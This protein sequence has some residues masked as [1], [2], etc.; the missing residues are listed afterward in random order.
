VRL[1][2]D[3]TLCRHKGPH[4]FGLGNHLDAA[5]STK[6]TKVF[7]FGHVW[8]VLALVVRVP[9]ARRSFA[10]PLLL[11]LHRNEKDCARNGAAYRPKTALARE[12]IEVVLGCRG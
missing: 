11:R 6:R 2:V 3:D 5:R 12:L 8:V 10:L 7:A 1:V 9:F 4:V